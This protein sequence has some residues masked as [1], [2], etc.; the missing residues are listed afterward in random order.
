LDS[1]VHLGLG[2]GSG[3]AAIIGDVSTTN[4][5]GVVWGGNWTND[6]SKFTNIQPFPATRV[7]T[8]LTLGSALDNNNT[9]FISGNVAATAD[10]VLF[11]VDITKGSPNFTIDTFAATAAGDQSAATFLAQV[12]SGAPA[13]VGYSFATN[14][15]KTIAF[16]ESNGVLNTAQCWWNNASAS[17]EIC[18]LAVVLLA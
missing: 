5:I 10:R 16:S 12:Q 7:G 9:K 8:T 11:F 15:A 3:T 4:F 6:G 1:S 2:L 18:D 17:P 14:G 13:L